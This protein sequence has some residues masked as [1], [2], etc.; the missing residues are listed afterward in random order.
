MELFFAFIVFVAALIIT[1]TFEWSMAIALFVGLVV[2]VL[3]GLNRKFLFRDLMKMVYIGGKTSFV[4]LRILVLI[5]LLTALWRSSG[6]ISFFVYYGIS[7]ISPSLFVLIT[8]LITLILSFALGTSFGIAG[9]AGVLLMVLAQSGGV[10]L[11]VTA[12]AV[13]SGAYFGDRCSPASSSA[14]LVAAVTFT[15]LYKNVKMMLLT[16]IIPTLV[17]LGIYLLLSI[18]N[19]IENVN[20]DVLDALKGTF[21]L[22]WLVALPALAIL[23]LPLFRVRVTYAMMASIIISFLLTIFLQDQE[24]FLVLETCIMGYQPESSLLGQV[25][26][27]GG[28]ISMIE[29]I[30]IVFISCTY[31]GVFDGTGMLK[32]TQEKIANLTNYIGLFPTQVVA[33]LLSIAVFCNQTV[34]TIINAQILGEVYKSKG[35]S[36]ENLAIDIE[37]SVI[38]LAG[39]IPWSIACTV[40]LG[41][42]GVGPEAIPYCVLLYIIP[43]SYLFTKKIWYKVY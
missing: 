36:S 23:V 15:K 25:M 33:S 22:S 2:F 9:T 41:I 7:M 8:F 1:L 27:G 20:T 30:I 32:D 26:A 18:S 37:N 6:T 38:T 4:V 24:F 21:N 43:L 42:L 28:L 12:G 16:G 31:A 19:P 5:G 35:A 14:S 11:A 39:I 13:M 3:T 40:P 34:A 29:V 10:S 17:S